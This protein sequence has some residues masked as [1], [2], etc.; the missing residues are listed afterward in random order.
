METNY[1]ITVPKP[2]HE[3][4]DK[5]TP[6]QTGRFCNSCVKSVVDF[7]DMKATE[8]QEYFIRNQGQKICGRF[9]T[10]QLDSV[11]I[12][13][14]RDVLFSQVQFHKIFMLA[15]LVSM[16]TTL[17]SC[18]NSN[19][20]K[21]KIDGVEVTDSTYT[22]T[23]VIL[24]KKDTINEEHVTLGKI[25]MK[26]YD[27]LVKAGVKM[28]PL[29]PPPPVKQVKFIKPSKE[30]VVIQHLTGDV[31]VVPETK[32]NEMTSGMVSQVKFL[33]STKTE[34]K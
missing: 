27:S 5:M 3:D 11:I 20:D 30:K 29:P 14:P 21:Q 15:L 19:G 9:K 12:Q 28:P 25:D 13:I 7:S 16:G 18:Q 26:R 34:K 6:D 24:P 32:K 4:W 2:C 23:G 22:T 8:I 1:K 10:E 17:F 31:K 33:D